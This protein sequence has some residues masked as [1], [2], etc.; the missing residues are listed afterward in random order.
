MGRSL[1]IDEF[2]AIGCPEPNTGCLLWTRSTTTN[3][4]GS[5]RW[6]GRAKQA[7][8]VA[9]E[10]THGPIPD[11]V[12]VMHSCDTR[13]CFEPKHLAL[14]THAMNMAD[15]ARKG[16]ANPVRGERTAQ[17]KLTEDA[18]RQIRLMRERGAPLANIASRYGVTAQAICLVVKRRN[19]SHVV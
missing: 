6:R 16:R 8:R 3:G 12:E 13:C 14:G 10:L 11:G 2:W 9:W 17:A 18:V 5:I 7:H 15:M 19:W 1:T 4:Y